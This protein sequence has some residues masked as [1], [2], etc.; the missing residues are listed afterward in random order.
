MEM[1]AYDVAESYGHGAVMRG[2]SISGL[3]PAEAVFWM[4]GG[5][6][7]LMTDYV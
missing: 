3:S 7:L 2:Q 5:A 1:S 4:I 6:A